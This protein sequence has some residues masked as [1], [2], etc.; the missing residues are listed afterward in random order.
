MSTLSDFCSTPNE[1]IFSYL[2]IMTRTNYIQWD[3][4]V[5][6]YVLDKHP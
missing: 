5:D 6:G 2:Y 4:N 1:Q 3:D